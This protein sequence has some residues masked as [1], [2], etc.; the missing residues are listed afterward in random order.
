MEEI[1]FSLLKTTVLLSVVGYICYRALLAIRNFRSYAK[2]FNDCPGLGGNDFHWLYGNLHKVRRRI[3]FRVVVVFFKEKRRRKRKKKNKKRDSL[4]SN[5]VARAHTLY[6]YVH[7]TESLCW[8]LSRRRGGLGVDPVGVGWEFEPIIN[9]A[10]R[11]ICVCVCVC[12]CV[13]NMVVNDVAAQYLKPAECS[14]IYKI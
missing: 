14:G 8:V 12:V 6:T 1:S 5:T 13:E 2:V 11:L 9:R 10:C 3:P 4:Y 7:T